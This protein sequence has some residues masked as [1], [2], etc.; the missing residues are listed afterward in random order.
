MLKG[1]NAEKG[2]TKKKEQQVGSPRRLE[3]GVDIGENG[4]HQAVARH[5]VKHAGLSQQHH[6][7]HGRKS[8][9]DAKLHQVIHP[10]VRRFVDG[11]RHRRRHAELGIRD[12][13]CED[14]G[15]QHV[16]HGADHQRA[17]DADGHVLLRVLGLLRGGGDGVE[18]DIGEEMVPAPIMMPLSPK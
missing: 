15:E 4:G 17:D 14:D 3:F 13:S 7:D 8:A 18:A 16:Q 6:Q 12:H 11:H 2:A 10:D 9:N 5:G 1:R